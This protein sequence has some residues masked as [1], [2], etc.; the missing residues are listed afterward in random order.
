MATKKR[1][2]TKASKKRAVVKKAAPTVLKI[3]RQPYTSTDEAL[4]EHVL[5][6]L[7]GKEAHAEFD[8]A[9]GGWPIELTGAKVANFPHTAWMLLEHMRI[10]QWDIL[11]FSR[12]PKHVSPK[13]PEGFLP[14]SEAPANE[15]AWTTAI[16]DFKKDMR[17]IEQLVASGKSDLFAKIPW[18]T[19]QTLL[20]EVLLV[21]DHNS[22]HLG[23][24]VM[25]RKC[26]GI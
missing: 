22:Y 3:N 23:Q 20:R 15:K 8:A 13:W 18:G 7:S 24:L 10:G 26:M 17:A 14:T 5:K 21:A 2:T 6:L 25:L 1:K 11:E 4:R 9:I 12:H 16:A 19:G